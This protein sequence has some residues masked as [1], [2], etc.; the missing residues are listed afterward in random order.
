MDVFD[1]RKQRSGFNNIPIEAAPS[2][3]TTPFLAYSTLHGN[4]QQP[5]WSVIPNVRHG[6]AAYR[7]LDSLE[8]E[9]HI[10]RCMFRLEN[11]VHMLGHEDVRPESEL[12]LL[13]CRINRIGQPLARSL[14]LEK[15][16]TP[17]AG[18]GQLVGMA[19]LID[20]RPPHRTLT[21]IHVKSSFP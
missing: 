6:L 15:A 16:V 12:Q 9:S 14:S 2:L 10:I 17:E 8:D 11:E 20:E 13:T 19:R 3:P 21:P 5:L 1:H 18:K 7:L 4:P